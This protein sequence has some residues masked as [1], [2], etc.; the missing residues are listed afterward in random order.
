MEAGLHQ[1]LLNDMRKL[2]SVLSASAVFAFAAALS[3]PAVHAQALDMDL[4]GA[5]KPRNIGP[6]GIW[7][8]LAVD[9]P[10]C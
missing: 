10:R 6:A 4:F 8:T 3:A 7:R 1:S 2:L 9:E 5:M